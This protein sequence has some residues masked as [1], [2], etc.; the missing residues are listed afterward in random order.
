MTSTKRAV[1]WSEEEMREVEVEPPVRPGRRFASGLRS[2]VT[3]LN[4]ERSRGMAHE[5]TRGSAVIFAPQTAPGPAGGTHGNFIEASYRRILARPEWARRLAKVHTAKRQARP[6]GPDEQV[7]E[8]R[9]LDAATSSDALLMNVFCYP[10]VWTA[11]LRALLGVTADA[12]VEFGVRARTPLLRGLVDRSEIDM[13]VGDL[14]VEAKLTEADFQFGTLRLLARYRDFE[15]VFEPDRLHMTRRGVRSYQLLRGVLAAYAMGGRFGVLCDARRPD[16]V[17]DWHAVIGAVRSFGL[18]SRLQLVTWQEVAAV[19]PLGLRKFL[20]G[21][22]GIEHFSCG[23][24]SEST[25]LDAALR[26]RK[27]HSQ[28]WSGPQHRETCS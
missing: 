10:R 6:A 18:Q 19:V 16:L 27:R 25:G 20:G 17:E 21:K 11:G 4:L 9:E 14:L 23:C 13:R 22:Y 28:E 24:Q 15:E 3:R 12:P 7:R 2:E 8:W 1:V 5:V 26:R